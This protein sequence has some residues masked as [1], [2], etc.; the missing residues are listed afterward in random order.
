MLFNKI[1]ANVLF[2]DDLEKCTAFYR[3]ILGIEVGFTD[4]ASVAFKMQ[5]TD[6][7]L[8]KA[9]AA[10][11]M[12]NEAVIA[13]DQAKGY[14]VL[15]CAGVENVD[16]VWQALKEKGVTLIKPPQDQPW[17]RRTAYF[18]DPEGNLWELFHHLS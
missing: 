14:R 11:D 1:D 18:A 4:D 9:P 13:F 15:M 3:D 12:M 6:F 5:G 8:L 2:V 16:T 17:G 10:A 7:V